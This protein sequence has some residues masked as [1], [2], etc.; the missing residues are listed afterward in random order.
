MPLALCWN[1]EMWLTQFT[2]NS[3]VPKGINQYDNIPN[4]G[5]ANLN[6]GSLREHA[7]IAQQA[8]G[9]AQ[10]AQGPQR[11]GKDEGLLESGYARYLYVYSTATNLSGNVCIL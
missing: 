9:E 10:A 11:A 8:K 5:L 2:F 7:V 4:Q 3:L 6:V 1:L